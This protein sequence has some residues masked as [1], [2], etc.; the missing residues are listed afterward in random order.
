MPR[1]IS[2]EM[3]EDLQYDLLTVDDAIKVLGKWER[4][5]PGSPWFKARCPLCKKKLVFLRKHIFTAKCTNE[6]T[7]LDIVIELRRRLAKLNN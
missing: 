2:T 5:R 4:S 3:P 7:L 1:G 6:C